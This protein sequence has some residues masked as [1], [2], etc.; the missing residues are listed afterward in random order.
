ME[1]LYKRRMGTGDQ[2][3]GFHPEKLYS[4]MNGDNAFLE[5]PNRESSQAVEEPGNGAVKKG[6]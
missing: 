6:A 2:C 4:P 1:Y 3:P 5:G